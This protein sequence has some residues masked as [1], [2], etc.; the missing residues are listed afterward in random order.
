[1]IMVEEQ[2]AQQ[3]L[4]IA[5]HLSLGSFAVQDHLWCLSQEFFS[6]ADKSVD[7]ENV[8]A[9]L[10]S[11]PCRHQETLAA[12]TSLPRNPHPHPCS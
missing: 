5:Y 7:R 10:L 6:E 12:L 4:R 8:L 3:I 11:G 2:L 9:A 1:M